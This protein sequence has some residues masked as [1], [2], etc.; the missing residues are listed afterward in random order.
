M[1]DWERGNASVECDVKNNVCMIIKMKT[2]LIQLSLT[3]KAR[4]SG[5]ATVQMHRRFVTTSHQ[6][7]P[8]LQLAHFPL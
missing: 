1:T 2:L 4:E 7:V 5:N 8:I 3:L 6:R